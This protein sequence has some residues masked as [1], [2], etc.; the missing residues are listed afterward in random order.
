MRCMRL[1]TLASLLAAMLM[2]YPSQASAAVNAIPLAGAIALGAV[3]TATYYAKNPDAA[4]DMAASASRFAHDVW[5]ANNAINSAVSGT[6][7]ALGGAL[8]ASWDD[9]LAKMSSE[10][11]A[12]QDYPAFFQYLESLPQKYTPN[13]GAP[14][15]PGPSSWSYANY[16][17]ITTSVH[18]D[19][20]SARS[21]VQAAASG[22]AYASGYANMG[23]FTKTPQAQ[24]IEVTSSWPNGWTFVFETWRG[25]V[26]GK[27][28]GHTAFFHSSVSDWTATPDPA[29]VGPG[30][31]DYPGVPEDLRQLIKDFGSIVHSF[32]GTAEEAVNATEN[33]PLAAPT[34][35]EIQAYINAAAAA[36]GQTALAAAQAALA[37][38]PTNLELQAKVAKLVAEMAA[39]DAEAVEEAIEEQISYTPDERVIDWSP[40]TTAAHNLGQCFP[41]SGITALGSLVGLLH[42]EGEAPS[43]QVPIYGGHS[44]TIDLAVVDPLAVMIRWFLGIFAVFMTVKQVVAQ[45]GP[46]S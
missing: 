17:Q 6:A 12:A 7:Y 39:S 25:S 16:E 30:A 8:W 13:A 4:H 15:A 21:A 29:A 44:L 24:Y 37:A 27:Y 35:A 40:L 5:A 23:P 31:L 26:E 10:P 41:I 45:W 36:A 2:V 18:P 1:F 32:A 28:K 11:N 3:G 43:W 46:K 19:L 14:L 20:A 33:K 42:T 34:A 38:D 22:K 9:A